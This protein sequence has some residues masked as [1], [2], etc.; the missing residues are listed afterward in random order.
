MCSHEQERPVKMTSIQWGQIL[1]LA[2]PGL[3]FFLTYLLKF[4]D[5]PRVGLLG[6]FLALI[7]LVGPQLEDVRQRLDKVQKQL[8]ELR[9]KVDSP[10]R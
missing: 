7:G 9:T 8:E 3:C 1:C 10:A 6:V 5:D 2:I 4:A